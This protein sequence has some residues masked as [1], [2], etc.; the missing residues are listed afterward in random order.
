MLVSLRPRGS[1]CPIQSFAASFAASPWIWTKNKGIKR[2]HPRLTQR[3][4]WPELSSVQKYVLIWFF[5]SRELIVGSLPVT[6][7]CSK[8]IRSPKRQDT[9]GLTWLAAFFLWPERQKKDLRQVEDGALFTSIYI[10]L[11]HANTHESIL[12]HLYISI[13]WALS[14]KWSSET[15]IKR[16]RT[17]PLEITRVTNHFPCSWLHA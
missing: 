15:W 1:G 7:F 5:F 14:I 13:L 17:S 3:G 8:E 11:P 16:T 10:L 2:I 4:M 9:T 12:C 6:T